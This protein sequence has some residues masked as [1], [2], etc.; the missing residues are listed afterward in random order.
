MN[1]NYQYYN[2]REKYRN[3]IPPRTDT[4]EEIYNC[5]VKEKY[6]SEFSTNEEKELVLNNLG[7]SRKLQQILNILSDKV[8]YDDLETPDLSN[9]VTLSKLNEYAKLSKL[10]E[11][12]KL[13]DLER[14]LT[15]TEFL[16]RVEELTPK[17]DS[18][19]G[20][21][22]SFDSLIES[23]PEA[24][25]GDWAIVN[26]DGNWYVYRYDKDFTWKQAEEYDNSIDL[27]E[28][29]KLIDLENLQ[30]RLI[31]GEN[32]KTINGQSI[33]G[34]GNIE[35][36]GGG[37]PS[38]DYVNREELENYVTKEE[39]FNIQNP[40]KIT[41]TVSPTIVEY[42]GNPQNINITVQ[43]KK[44]NNVVQADSYRIQY[45]NITENFNGNYS[46][47]ISDNG[48][49][50]FTI[51]CNYRSEQTV[52]TGS[53]NFV[54]PSYFGFDNVNDIDLVN[55]NKLTKRIKGNIQATETLQ[56]EISGSYLWI[57]TP[58][59]LNTVATDAGYTYKVN[60]ILAGTKNG[61]NYYRSNSAVDISNLTYYIK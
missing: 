49:T 37:Q 25:T 35:I 23:N 56:N 7:I 9:Y 39:L 48:V 54:L 15:V 29:A 16:R 42:T 5:L 18:S 3:C 41:I 22:S 27:S 36:Q 45:K 13:S 6:L 10:D 57:V 34:R 46:A 11:Y 4:E 32:I 31:S 26:V 28:Y 38:E 21:Y 2:N 20:Y 52:G 17:D 44:G 59:T 51:T 61:L 55:L 60:M 47:S 33:L 1:K 19:K 50:I 24:Q 40:L 12:A 8:N 14:Y 30:T 58:Y 53:V 43:A